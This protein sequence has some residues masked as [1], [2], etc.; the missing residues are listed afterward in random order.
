MG[1][2]WQVGQAPTTVQV[3]ACHRFGGIDPAVGVVVDEHGPAGQAVFGVLRQPVPIRVVPQTP[4]GRPGLLGVVVGD[5]EGQA[6]R[7]HKSG[8]LALDRA[9]RELHAGDFRGLDEQVVHRGDLDHTR[10]VP[11][12]RTEDE[13]GG[14]DV[15]LVGCGDRHLHGQQRCRRERYPHRL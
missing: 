3:A 9:Q 1:A 6:A 13:R 8:S 2:R 7:V 5:A 15:Q 12:L 11:V 10:L 4:A 14:V